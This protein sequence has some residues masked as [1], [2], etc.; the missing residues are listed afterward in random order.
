MKRWSRHLCPGWRSWLPAAADVA[1][2]ASV[3]SFFVSRVDTAVDKAAGSAGRAPSCKAKSPSPTPR[4][5][6][7]ASRSFSPLRAG[8]N[9]PAGRACPA[10]AVGQHR[11]QEPGLF[12][13]ALRGRAGWPAHGQYPA[14]S[15]AAGG[16]GSR[17]RRAHHRPGSET[18]LCP[19]RP[20]GRAGHRPGRHYPKAAGRWCGCLC[21][22]VRDR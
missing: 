5:L 13:H 3:A 22:I 10:P 11:H 9:W 7:P 15:H 12:R 1:R 6:T 16:A 2:L 20:P 4:S 14:A 19:N 8:R 17:A 21:Q 18:G